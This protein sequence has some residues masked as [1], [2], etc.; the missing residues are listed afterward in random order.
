MGYNVYYVHNF[1]TKEF[2]GILCQKL[3]ECIKMP[4]ALALSPSLTCYSALSA[5]IFC[6]FIIL[7]H[8][9]IQLQWHKNNIN[10][11]FTT[12]GHILRKGA[13]H[14]TC[15]GD[16]VAKETGIR[17]WSVDWCRF[18]AIHS[19]ILHYCFTGWITLLFLAQ[20]ELCSG[21]KQLWKLNAWK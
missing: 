16:C 4:N 6:L 19:I 2:G 7:L 12:S 9:C 15:K 17:K 10:T 8:V 18:S 5:V 11:L 21:N 3:L 1:S 14:F 20:D 13:S